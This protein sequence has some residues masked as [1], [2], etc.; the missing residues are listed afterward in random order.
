MH[1]VRRAAR[2]S[3]SSA[4]I[5]AAWVGR[6]SRETRERL[7]HRAADGALLSSGPRRN[8]KLAL[9]CRSVDAA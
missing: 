9:Q 5:R 2:G 7:P 1:R 8:E 6:D 4:G 3:S